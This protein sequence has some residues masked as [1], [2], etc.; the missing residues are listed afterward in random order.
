MRAP[1]QNPI[2]GAFAALGFIGLTATMSPLVFLASLRDP[3]G[4]DNLL[5]VWGRESLRL[6]GVKS[7]V[8]GLENIPERTCVFVSNHQ[9]HFDAL[10]T[11]THI[12]KHIRFVAKRELFKIPLF[13]QALRA[14]GNIE[15]DR[16]G[17]TGDRQKLESAIE[18][19]R[20]R[21]SVLFYPEGTR[22]EDGSLLPF[23]KGAA[24]FAIQAGMPIIPL[25]IAGTKDILR[26][27]TLSIHRGCAAAL[28]VGKPIV[29]DGLSLEDRDALTHTMREAIASQMAEAE[30]LAAQL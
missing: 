30:Q 28:V 11:F 3:R 9:S 6:A 23:R 24:I 8:K 10:V 16:S 15:V 25:A 18:T 21:T 7:T 14:A 26:K 5:H 20:E 19:A 12:R 13:G 17:G 2:S 1:S 4:S 29:T 27:K 22:S